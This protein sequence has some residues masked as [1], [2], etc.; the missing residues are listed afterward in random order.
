MLAVM[1]MVRPWLVLVACAGCLDEPAQPPGGNHELRRRA[2]VGDFDGDG[3]DDVLTLGHDGDPRVDAYVFV[4]WGCGTDSTETK[5]AYSETVV[6]APA[7]YEAIDA[8]AYHPPGDSQPTTLVVTTGQDQV[9]PN[10][11]G[12]TRAIA[13]ASFTVTGHDLVFAGR[14]DVA[15]T[16]GTGG[17]AA[18]IPN[19]FVFERDIDVTGDAEIIYGDQ[20]RQ[21]WNQLTPLRTTDID[22][23]GL[24]G[25]NESFQGFVVVPYDLDATEPIL[26]VTSV[27]ARVLTSN[28]MGALALKG[29]PQA[30]ASASSSD[31]SSRIVRDRRVGGQLWIGVLETYDNRKA[32]LVHYDLNGTLTETDIVGPDGDGIAELAIIDTGATN[33]MGSTRIDLFAIEDGHTE[34]YSDVTGTPSTTMGMYF[35]TDFDL[36]AEGHFNGATNPDVVYIYNTSNPTQPHMCFNTDLTPCN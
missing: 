17:Y 33:S 2:L 21:L 28:G 23:T 6:Q 16:G 24:L 19:T 5:L 9:L 15:D 3:C 27:N 31:F 8:F 34:L 36:I 1:W 29:T 25:T 30:L 35:D 14:T 22:A 10:P 26:A 13:A 7:W 11:N 18:D 20:S 32:S 4:D 12:S